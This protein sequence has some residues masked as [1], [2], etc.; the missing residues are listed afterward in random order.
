MKEY[1]NK[2]VHGEFYIGDD[3]YQG[4]LH[5]NGLQT[6]LELWSDSFITEPTED[7]DFIIKGITYG[8]MK[9]VTLIDTIMINKGSCNLRKSDESISRYFIIFHPRIVVIGTDE[10]TIEHRIKRFNIST[11]NLGEV[12]KDHKMVN[13]INTPKAKSI[14]KLIADDNKRAKDMFGFTFSDNNNYDELRNPSVYIYNG[15]KEILSTET[16]IGHLSVYNFNS[17]SSFGSKGFYIDISTQFE[18]NLTNNLSINE[19]VSESWKLLDFIKIISGKDDYISE[20][21][22]YTGDGENDYYEVYVSTEYNNI[23]NDHKNFDSLINSRM[24]TKYLSEILKTWLI[25]SHEWKYA[26]SQMAKSYSCD[27]YDIDR[28]IRSANIFDLIPCKNKSDSKIKLNSEL[29]KAK[30]DAKAIFKSLP[31]S[32]ERESMLNAIGRI[33]TKTLKHKINDRI[34]IIE[35]NSNININNIRFVSGHSVD[36]RNYF[37]HGSLKRFDYYEHDHLVRFFTDTLEF[38]FVV[39]DLIECGWNIND[40]ISLGLYNHK[41]SNYL[42]AYEHYEKNLKKTLSISDT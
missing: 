36:C 19:V 38:I 32:I 4:E 9:V 7:V 5:F 42:Y 6:K 2:K 3:R 15:N 41:V 23:N 37:V 34:D 14:N 24:D 22:F 20:F 26:R 25:S 35:K 31:N 11:Y 17:K 28:L 27:F 1:V 33:G 40:W 10:Y 18:F 29:N 8:E 39:S 13:Y 12:F 30:E 16:D 21:D